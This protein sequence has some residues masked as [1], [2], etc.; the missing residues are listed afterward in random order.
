MQFE[1]AADRVRGML[2]RKSRPSELSDSVLT[3]DKLRDNIIDEALDAAPR[4]RASFEQDPPEIEYEVKDADG[5]VQE[6]KKY[7]WSTFG[8]T[9]KD[10][11]RA[12]FGLDEPEVLGRDRI[13][14]RRSLD[15]EVI[16]SAVAD[17]EFQSQR[18]YTRDN[19]AESLYGTM[20]AAKSLKES[21]S[22]I[23]AEHIAREE[24]IGKHE[25][26]LDDAQKRIDDLRKRAKKAA[27]AGEAIPGDIGT[28]M[29]KQIKRRQAA[30][31]AINALIQQAQASNQ[32]AAAV[33]AG[34]AA[35]AAGRDAAETMNALNS[36]P[37]VGGGEAHNVPLEQQI[38]LAE[39]WAENDQ[40]KAILAQLGRMVHD[41]RFK[42]DTR[43]SNVNIEPVGIE[44]GADLGR[45][46]PHELARG[47]MGLDKGS[48]AA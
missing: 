32:T 47:F 22:T 4:V 2:N 29:R 46:L 33:E 18:P 37:G 39:K 28:K 7:E 30:V 41:M 14:P 12:S 25:S 24:E 20:A 40:L 34:E 48:E 35:A 23:L 42:R 44:T 15:R 1:G 45:L 11:A 3:P 27:D 26:E 31:A 9:L 21:A 43:T 16:A 6:V 38:E 5:K 19:T 13:K 8:E 17:G 10:Y 36:L